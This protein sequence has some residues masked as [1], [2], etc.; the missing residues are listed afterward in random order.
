MARWLQAA[1]PVY[2]LLLLLIP[3]ADHAFIASQ[4][5]RAVPIAVSRPSLQKQAVNEHGKTAKTIFVY[6]TRA[7]PATASRPA[8]AE[9]AFLLAAPV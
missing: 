3:N 1:S 9:P 4:Q 7:I 5:T 2:D 6:K 8:A